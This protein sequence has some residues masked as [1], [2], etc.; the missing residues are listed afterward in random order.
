MAAKRKPRSVDILGVR[1]DDVT[2]GEALEII[3]TFIAEGGPHQI[4]TP[5]PEFVVYAQK[6]PEFR[7]V[8]NA[9]A[10]S[11]PDG[12][13]LL[14]AGRLLK[15]PIREQVRGTDLAYR[16]MERAAQRGYSVFLLGAAPGVAEEAGRRFTAA[17]P[18]LRVIGTYAGSAD[19]AA[20]EQARSAIMSQGRPD[21]I[22]VAF[23]APKQDMW[24]ARNLPALGIP[25]GIGVGGVF[26]FVSG[27]VK[28]A[29]LWM[30]RLGLE[31]LYRLIKQPWRWRRQLALPRFL[32]FVLH[33][34]L[35]NWF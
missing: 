3:E 17:Y 31:W 28:R 19:A 4:A 35:G 2:Y 30:R 6:C 15:R 29:P 27:R 16:L 21:I 1:V 7:R 23:G 25:V 9:S 12:G 24:L 26:D 32:L 11:I 22:L 14:I 5:N 33:S 10:L 18:G 13:G 8:L 20:D 34:R